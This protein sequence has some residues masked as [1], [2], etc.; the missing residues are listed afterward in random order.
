MGEA[1]ISSC[2][3]LMQPQLQ[4]SDSS[5][6]KILTAPAATRQSPNFLMCDGTGNRK[7]RDIVREALRQAAG[8]GLNVLRTFAHTTDENFRFQV[9]PVV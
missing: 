9:R 3:P 1:V 2:I 4:S 6:C 7:G 5:S 8:S